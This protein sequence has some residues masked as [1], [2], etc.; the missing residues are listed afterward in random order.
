QESVFDETAKPLV[1]G[2]LQGSGKNGLVIA[3]GATNAGKTH[4][5]MGARGEDDGILPRTLAGVYERMMQGAN[6]GDEPFRVNF[7]VVEIYM[8]KAYDLLRDEKE[9][10]P[11]LSFREFQGDDR[12][13]GLSNHYP[14][15]LPAALDLVRQARSKAPVSATAL[16]PFSSRGHTVWMIEVVRGGG[17]GAVA[18]TA[19]SRNPM[20][21]IVDLAGSERT[22]RSMSNHREAFN[23]NSDITNVFRCFKMVEAGCLHVPFRT[24]TLTRMLKNVLV[25]GA[26]SVDP[27]MSCVMV[28]NVNPAASEYGETQK[29]LTNALIS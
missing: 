22:E 28:V 29:V 10:G 5:I 16:N 8:D 9:R 2:L 27:R 1:E 20:L 23:I 3:Y 12:M 7:R 15:D 26:D 19:N 4:T 25:R 11:A 14:E 21:W 17:R 24:R 6:G 18:R 13:E